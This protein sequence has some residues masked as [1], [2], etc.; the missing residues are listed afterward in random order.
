MVYVD[1]VEERRIVAI[2]PRPPFRSLFEIATT[3]EG[4][5]ILLVN[6]RDLEKAHQPPPHGHEADTV[7]CSWWR[8][9]RVELPVQKTR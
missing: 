6:E 3:R 2:R 5:G 1:T 7:S 4:S 9:G 8:R